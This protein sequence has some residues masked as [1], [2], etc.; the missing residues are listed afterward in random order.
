MFFRGSRYQ[1]VPEGEYG[2]PDGRAIRHK[3][4]RFTPPVS[5]AAA[6]TTRQNDRLDLLAYQFY[7]DPEQFWRIADANRCLRPQELVEQPGRRLA[8][9]LPLT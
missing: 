7:Q 9:P 3:R 8:A 2:A 6:Y 1:T 5:G 4:M